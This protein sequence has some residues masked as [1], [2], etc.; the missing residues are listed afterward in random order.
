MDTAPLGRF[1]LRVGRIA[2]GTATFGSKHDVDQSM[3]LL[4]AA[5][6][7]GV[8]LVD[9]SD[10]YPMPPL[11]QPVGTAESIVGRW[12]DRRPRPD[13]VVA[14][15]CGH[16]TSATGG[17]ATGSRK[18]VI[19]SCEASLR[20]L[21][22]DHVDI[23]YL[24]R[25]DLGAPMD[26]TLAAVDVLHRQGKVHYFGLSNFSA[27]QVAVV[28]Q[29][30]A[31]RGYMPVA[32]L[33]PRFNLLARNPERDLLPLATALGIGVIPYN[34]VA[35]GVLAGRFTRDAAAGPASRFGIGGQTYRDRYWSDEAF[36]VA[37][38]VGRVADALG[39]S[40]A[41]VAVAW[42][43]RQDVVTSVL[44]GVSSVEQLDDLVGAFGVHLED[45]HLSLL[46]TVSEPFAYKA[47]DVR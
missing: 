24:H 31:G 29:E 40:P 9:T 33:E 41:Q 26:E 6:D 7:R 22:R 45:E 35:A 23:Y 4:D 15:K 16:V 20:R 44:A 46:D 37:D 38:A 47:G 34:P 32:A 14:S 28:L 3:R 27:W 18:Y 11:S 2:I 12:L 30:I 8:N 25:P 5:V 42:L 36:T 21:G 43:L 39:A 10:N 1:G 17:A 13:V 19:E